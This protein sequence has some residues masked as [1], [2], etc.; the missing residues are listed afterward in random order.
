[1]TGQRAGGPET[2]QP[3]PDDHSVLPTAGPARSGSGHIRT[4]HLPLGSAGDR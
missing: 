3:S 1:M 4:L 2:G